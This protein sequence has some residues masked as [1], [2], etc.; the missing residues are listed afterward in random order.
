VLTRLALLAGSLTLCVVARAEAPAPDAP[1]AP[2]EE[3]P[4]AQ[5]A[6]PAGAPLAVTWRGPQALVARCRKYLAAPRPEAGRPRAGFL[7]PWVREVRRRVPEIAA[8]EGYFSAAV[9][10]AFNEARQNA[11]VTVTP[12]PRT[13]VDS[14]DITFKGDLAGAGPEREKRRA[15]LREGW[16]LA[17]GAAFVSADWDLAKTRFEE[18]LVGV[19]YA[20]GSLAGT[21]AE[22]DAESAKAHL[23]IVADSGPRFT[24]GGVRI[25]GLERYPE[26]V[27]RRLVDLRRGER[28]SSA[29]LLEL[30][31]L[32]QSGPWFSSVIAGIDP[33]AAH[34]DLVPV[35]L[36]VSERPRRDVGV[37]LGYG[38]DDGA[39]GEA[40]YRDRDLL[41]RGF[42]LQ[43]ALRVSQKRQIGYADV[44]LPPG[45]FKLGARGDVPFT[46]SVGVLAEHNT[47]QNLAISRFAAAGYRHFT[48]DKFELRAGLSYQVE[49][50][51]P[52][53][54]DVQIKRALAPIVA[55]TWR[56]VDDVFDPRHGGVLNVQFAAGSKALASGDNFLKAYLQYQYWIDLGAM[57]QI[58]LRTE[59]GRTFAPSRQNL[60]EDFLFRA[61]GARSNRGYA[62]QS[63]GVQEGEAIVGGRFLATGTVEYVH[64][65]NGKW[66]G[67]LFTDIGGAADAPGD[68]QALKSYGVG[69]RYRT[70]AGPLAIDLA[71]A[72]RDH[73]FR[74][75]FSVTV[76]F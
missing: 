61:G 52:Q 23:T 29:R 32:V 67:A 18:A 21:R 22:V 72:S 53:G 55:M 66:G 57:D 31:H 42:D 11:T 40:A 1:D 17:K 37:S 59:L 69:A 45:L 4:G 12:G 76:A 38:T 60:P 73:K 16:T 10:V 44:Y 64:W 63:L 5:P 74:L 28:Y 68:L 34:P 36:S 50:D 51:Y 20:A 49:R 48:L 27:V 33:D 7:R 8:A 9:D 30:Q 6:S 41:G 58:L 56:H 35:T 3:R 15:R 39:R 2:A 26:A 71:Y 19:D 13:V 14:I 54:S 75:A 47:I 46:D 65:L 62:Y 70:P 43:S 24:L 25:V